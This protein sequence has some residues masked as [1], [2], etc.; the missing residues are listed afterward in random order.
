M[1]VFRG[2]LRKEAELEE[3]D[4]HAFIEKGKSIISELFKQETGL[5]PKKVEGSPA[6][7]GVKF[8]E[9][10][11]EII[12]RRKPKPVGSLTHQN[13]RSKIALPDAPSKS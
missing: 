2:W 6:K 7:K 11:E 1:E 10:E 5:K 12:Q 8:G 3:E 9:E 4:R 13:T